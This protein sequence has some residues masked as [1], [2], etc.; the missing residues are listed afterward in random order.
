MRVALV[1]RSFNREGSLPRFSVELARY[2]ARR[3]EVHVYSIGRRTDPTLAPSCRFYDVHTW[4]MGGGAGFSARELISF[5]R[6]SAKLVERERYDV[7]HVRAPS[8]WIGDVLHVPGVS[9]GE[10]AGQQIP[11]WKMTASTIRHP[12]NAARRL[13]E[14]R[15]LANPDLRRIHVDA[16]S[17]RDDLERYHGI[18]PTN[19]L[20]AV[21]GVNL[22]EFRVPLDRARAR[23]AA[24][25][26]DERLVLLF[27]GHD[28][29]RKGLDRAIHG[30]AA[31]R[32]DAVLLVVGRNPDE[33]R[34][35]ALADAS[36]VGDR[37]CFLG[38][39]SDAQA[40]Y[41][42]ADAFVLP[43]LAD[44]WGVTVIEA[45]ACGTP[46]IVTENAGAAAAVRDGETGFVLPEPFDVR[47]LRDAI[48]RLADPALRSAMGAAS[49]EAARPYGWDEHGR[50][51]ETDLFDVAEGRAR[52][53]RRP[54]RKARPWRVGQ[55][56]L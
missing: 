11:P 44:V 45:M 50:L 56:L 4:A 12:G 48:D 29:A 43:T 19:V 28:F 46:P 13:I 33:A 36:G 8:T 27:C 52:L 23:L 49:A 18:D 14:W 47:A 55:V 20:V 35:R 25:I 7:V 51:V 38:N 21:P 39:R 42:A 34:Y 54:A 17:V 37:V 1:Y 10:A 30:L 6:A 26:T 5:A 22:D 24:G 16:P 15:A 9:R 31:A 32:A 40:L 3:H 41:Q 53:V 2:L